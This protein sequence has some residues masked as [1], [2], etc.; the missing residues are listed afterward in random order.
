MACW[1]H[2]SESTGFHRGQYTRPPPHGRGTGFPAAELKNSRSGGAWAIEPGR[3]LTL[4][5]LVSSSGKGSL[6][7]MAARPRKRTQD[8]APWNQ[9]FS[10][11]FPA[12]VCLCVGERVQGK[13]LCMHMPQVCGVRGQLG[14][15]LFSTQLP[16]I[17]LRSGHQTQYTFGLS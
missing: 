3:H 12:S 10:F 1:R 7:D 8:Q 6:C 13:H 5:G 4:V 9:H 11:T 2:A 17:E 15:T 14:G 16:D